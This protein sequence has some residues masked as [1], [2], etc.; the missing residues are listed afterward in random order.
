MAKS[1]IK[2]IAKRA[3]LST[4][5]V[6]LALR[7]SP[8]VTGKTREKVLSIAAELNYKRNL[9]GRIFSLQKT[10]T[11]GL[12]IPCIMHSFWPIVAR[13]VEGEANK[14]G[15]HL[16]FCHSDNKIAKEVSEVNL[17]RERRVDGLIIAPTRD[18]VKKDNIEIYQDLQREKSPVVLINEYFK[19]VE[20]SYVITDDRSG[21]Y[22][23]VTYLGKL[24]HQRIGYIS[25]PLMFLS[26]QNRLKGYQEALTYH[27]IDFNPEWVKEGGF[28]EEDGYK[29]LKEFLQADKRPTAIFAVCD[30]VALGAWRALNESGLKV[31][32]DMA[33]IGYG[34]EI[35]RG[36]MPMFE[37]LLTT[38]RQPAAEIGKRAARI[39]I[40]E[41]EGKSKGRQKIILP[42]ELII[43][44]SSG[45]G[46]GAKKE[47]GG[48]VIV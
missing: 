40:D 23:A 24:G 41:V 9:L 26:C 38:V 42:T 44:K 1:T 21:A 7:D 31:P 10:D 3:R 19:E 15:Y 37:T 33:V 6:S 39:L 47:E 20:T 43:G 25:G 45:A 34:D 16:I 32:E 4:S 46:P 12:V 27:N 18:A 8:R 35:N 30:E 48:T 14:R 17:L 5:T 11:L 36:S 22:K 28:Y 13:A 29:A 2:E